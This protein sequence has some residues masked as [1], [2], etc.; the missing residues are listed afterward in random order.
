MRAVPRVITYVIDRALKAYWKAFKP[1]TFGVKA[2]ILHPLD[3]E[4]CVLI[5]QSYG[6]RNRWGL[7]GGGY[8]PKKELAEAAVRRECREEL[9]LEFEP[10][11]DVLEELLTTAEGKRDHL[12]I[13][14]VTARSDQLQLNREVMEAVWTPLDYSGLPPGAPVSRFADIAVSAHRENGY[15]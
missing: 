2:L 10:E 15:S 1:K 7:P 8:R 11:T 3:P 6:D 12:T 14:R 9:G 5:R 4:L 13:F